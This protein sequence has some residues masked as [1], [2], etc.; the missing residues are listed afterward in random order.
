MRGRCAWREE[1]C[2]F[3]G[4]RRIGDHGS[5]GISDHAGDLAG[6]RNLSRQGMGKANGEHEQ[7]AENRKQTTHPESE[8]TLGHGAPREIRQLRIFW[9]DIVY[10]TGDWGCQVARIAPVP[11]LPFAISTQSEP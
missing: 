4:D 8:S 10:S 5:G 9:W 6:D 11:M 3:R 7:E 2:T 1:S